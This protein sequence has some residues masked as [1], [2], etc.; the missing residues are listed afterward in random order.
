MSLRKLVN[1]GGAVALAAG[2]TLFTAGCQNPTPKPKKPDYSSEISAMNKAAERLVKLQNSNG[3]WDWIVTNA[4]GPT[5]STYLNIAGVTAE[6][7][8]AADSANGNSAYLNGAEATGDYL[9]IKF[10]ADGSNA[11]LFQSGSKTNINAFNVR[12]LYDL[13]KASG[14]SSFTT[15]ANNLMSKVMTAYPDPASLIAADQAARG[16]GNGE[17]IVPWDLFLYTRNAKSAGNNSWAKSLETDLQ[18]LSLPPSGDATYTLG[19]AAESMMGNAGATQ[20]LKANQLADGTWSDPNGKAQNTA[21]AAM[22][23][24]KA[25][26]TADAYKAVQSA[27]KHQLSN[28]GWTESDGTEYSE[29]DSEVIM[30]LDSYINQ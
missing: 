10:G 26:D 28:G 15:L 21:Y 13:G 29:V 24:V 4:T 27:E 16:T 14:D 18:A 3:S 2:L 1:L 6:G 12:F 17:G 25:G 7:L 23:L 9:K 30:A 11:T 22:A 8:L 19:L 20:A 5:S